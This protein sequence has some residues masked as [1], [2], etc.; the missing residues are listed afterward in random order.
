MYESVCVCVYVVLYFKY[1]GSAFKPLLWSYILLFVINSFIE[2]GLGMCL[3]TF[4]GKAKNKYFERKHFHCAF[5]LICNRTVQHSFSWLSQAYKRQGWAFP[6]VFSFVFEKIM[7]QSIKHISNTVYM[8]YTSLFCNQQCWSIIEFSFFLFFWTSSKTFF[9]WESE[10]I[11]RTPKLQWKM[12][13]LSPA[14]GKLTVQ[15]GYLK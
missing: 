8:K 4:L 13:N 10:W 3:K 11:K 15:T 6:F 7:N 2:G 9:T 5:Q 1:Y 12:C 14:G